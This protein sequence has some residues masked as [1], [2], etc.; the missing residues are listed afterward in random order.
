MYRLTGDGC[1][2]VGCITS[3]PTFHV[4]RGNVHFRVKLTDGDH[5]QIGS[6]MIIDQALGDE[7][8]LTAQA[9]CVFFSPKNTVCS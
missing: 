7:L 2:L 4:L 6:G 8:Y 5:F 3:Q 1:V 9:V